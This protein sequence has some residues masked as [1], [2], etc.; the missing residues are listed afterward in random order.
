MCKVLLWGG[1]LFILNTFIIH[2]FHFHRL[3]P[4]WR[5]FYQYLFKSYGIIIEKLKKNNS[6][7]YN[8]QG[9]HIDELE[10]CNRMA[11]GRTRDIVVSITLRQIG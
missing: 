2:I 8:S 6:L 1:I 11:D 7:T 5:Q 9:S 10:F 4:K 3:T